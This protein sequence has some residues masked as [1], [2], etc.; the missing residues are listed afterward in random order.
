[1]SECGVTIGDIFERHFGISAM[2]TGNCPEDW[3][4]P[5][6]FEMDD[7]YPITSDTMQSSKDVVEAGE[8]KLPKFKRERNL[9]KRKANI[10]NHCKMHQCSDY[11][12]KRKVRRVKYDPAIHTSFDKHTIKVGDNKVDVVTHDCRMGFGEL[13]K[14]ETVSGENNRTRGKPPIRD[15]AKIEPDDNGQPRF[16]GRRNHPRVLQAPYGFEFFAAN[17]DFQILII[18]ATSHITL[19]AR[20][21]EGYE[22]FANNLVAAGLGGL[23]HHNGAL[24]VEQYITGYMCK[25]DVSSHNWEVT[26]R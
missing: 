20:G 22:R 21:P 9:F 19:A 4:K 18:N 7:D 24:I 5:G 23:E 13:L 15:H 8:L 2:H 10:C 17:N 3:V 26:A 14:F 25:G 12:A 11:C 1:M 16:I 6:G